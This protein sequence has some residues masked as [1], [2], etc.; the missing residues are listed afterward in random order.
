VGE[1]GSPRS[2][3]TGEGYLS[4]SKHL[5]IESCG[6]I[7][8]IRRATR[9]TFSHKGRRKKDHTGK[10]RFNAGMKKIP[11]LIAKPML[12]RIERSVGRLPR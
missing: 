11:R 5:T 2:G 1:G 12:Q 7:P 9:A 6:E 10:N 8:L 4:A 3:E